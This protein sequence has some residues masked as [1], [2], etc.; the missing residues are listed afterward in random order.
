MGKRKDSSDLSAFG[1]MEAE[2]TGEQIPDAPS[3]EDKAA[4]K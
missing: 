3:A 1:E 2:Y 4:M